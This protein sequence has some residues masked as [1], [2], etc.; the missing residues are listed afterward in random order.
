MALKSAVTA[1]R[2]T[3][4]FYAVFKPARNMDME[5]SSNYCAYFVYVIV[6]DDG[7]KQSVQSIQHVDNLQDRETKTSLINFARSHT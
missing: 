6:R 3:L 1:V 4:F 5:S 7:I 2:Y